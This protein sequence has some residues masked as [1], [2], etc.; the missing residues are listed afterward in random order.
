MKSRSARNFL[1]LRRMCESPDPFF[2][3]TCKNSCKRNHSLH[4]LTVSHN[5]S[6]VRNV[7]WEKEA[8]NYWIIHVIISKSLIAALKKAPSSFSRGKRDIS[9]NAKAAPPPPPP[10]MAQ[11]A[12][13]SLPAALPSMTREMELGATNLKYMAAPPPPPP[14]M[15]LASLSQPPVPPLPPRRSPRYTSSGPTGLVQQ[16][17]VQLNRLGSIRRSSSLKNAASGPPQMQ[18]FSSP[19]APPGAPMG[20]AALPGPPPPPLPSFMFA[21]QRQ[22][23]QELP[24][25]PPPPQQ[26]QQRKEIQGTVLS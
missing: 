3:A 1:S 17:Q 4:T 15:N 20:F 18:S 2:E 22:Q 23:Q 12:S 24:P 5:K 8:I 16:P 9:Q 11:S 26:Q 6:L 19:L 14:M 7:T 10:A 21:Q 25:P 13:F